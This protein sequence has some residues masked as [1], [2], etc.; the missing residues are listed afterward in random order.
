M[1]NLDRLAPLIPREEPGFRDTE[2]RKADEHDR[3]DDAWSS[4]D[5][6]ALAKAILGGFEVEAA[7]ERERIAMA[8]WQVAFA[9]TIHE[10]FESDQFKQ[11]DIICGAR[12]WR[13]FCTDKQE[14]HYIAATR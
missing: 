8:G 9:G 12:G 2:Q 1:Y 14:P 10:Y 3:L 11:D 5:S 13:V 4:D 7:D 6:R